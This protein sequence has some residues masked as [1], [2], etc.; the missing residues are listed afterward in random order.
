MNLYEIYNH[1][2]LFTYAYQ[3][4]TTWIGGTLNRC[5]SS[6][7]EISPNQVTIRFSLIKNMTPLSKYLISAQNN[8]ILHSTMCPLGGVRGLL[9][10]GMAPTHTD[11]NWEIVKDK[12]SNGLIRTH[13]Q[14]KLIIHFHHLATT[15]NILIV[16]KNVIH[17]LYWRL[18]KKLL[19]CNKNFK[20]Q[21]FKLE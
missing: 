12:W 9:S 19:F 21:I 10:P 14:A 1:G 13:T 7:F 2:L 18:S 3:I 8:L 15:W 4:S 6:H 16:W 5:I 17:K 20:S 11:F